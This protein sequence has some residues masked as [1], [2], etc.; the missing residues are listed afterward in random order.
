MDNTG[1]TDSDL[2][3]FAWALAVG[4]TIKPRDRDELLAGVEAEQQRRAIDRLRTRNH[5][6]E[7]RNA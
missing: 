5:N 3:A 7:D 1:V 4:G 6:K 2:V